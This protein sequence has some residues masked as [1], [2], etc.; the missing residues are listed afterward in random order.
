MFRN[1]TKLADQYSEL[2]KEAILKNRDIV[3]D[4]STHEAS[5]L[6]KMSEQ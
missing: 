3:I 1:I 5:T 2:I 4:R 6:L